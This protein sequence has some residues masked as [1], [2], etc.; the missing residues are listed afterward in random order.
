MQN[1][2]GWFVN[3]EVLLQEQLY[4]LYDHFSCGGWGGFSGGLIFG[5]S[6][7]GNGVFY[8]STFEFMISTW[9]MRAWDLDFVW[10]WAH[11]PMNGWT[12]HLKSFIIYLMCIKSNW[13][14]DHSGAGRG[15]WTEVMHNSKFVLIF[16]PSS[17]YRDEAVP[18]LSLIKRI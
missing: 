10:L 2:Y 6:M 7:L 1:I 12:T 13:S 14:M 8:I 17:T 15:L 11:P 4:S 16:L 9:E 18:A 3:D 5:V